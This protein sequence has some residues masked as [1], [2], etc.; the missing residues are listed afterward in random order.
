MTTPP[1]VKPGATFAVPGASLEVRRIAGGQVIF[2]ETPEGGEWVTKALPLEKFRARLAP[3]EAQA[4][5][6][7]EAEP[8]I[9]ELE[10]EIHWPARWFDSDA[11]DVK[12]RDTWLTIL[13]IAG[14]FLLAVALFGYVYGC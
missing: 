4:S 14:M 1:E 12:P 3:E 6:L 8:E 2:H 11:R 10:P 9:E 7:Q 5:L 13:V